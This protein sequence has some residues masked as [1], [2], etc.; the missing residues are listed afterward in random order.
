MMICKIFIYQMIIVKVKKIIAFKL[1]VMIKKL[2]L[3]NKK[4]KQK[5]FLH[6]K[7]LLKKKQNYNSLKTI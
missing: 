1:M 6:N 2:N 4:W 3:N 7:N 5:I